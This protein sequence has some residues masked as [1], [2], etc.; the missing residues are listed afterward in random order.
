MNKAKK[1]QTDAVTDLRFVIAGGGTGGH[2]F[3][4]IALAQ[5]LLKKNSCTNILF[6]NSGNNFETSTLSA[7]GFKLKP[8]TSKGIKGRSLIKQMISAVKN[9][10]GVLQ[11]FRILKRF[12]PDIVIGVGGYSSGPVLFAA[13]LFGIKTVL[14]EQNTLP[15]IT[16]RILARFVC[17]IYVS[18]KDTKFKCNP[19]KIIFTGNPIKK[20]TIKNANSAT[21]KTEEKKYN[22]KKHND[23]KFNVFITGGSQGA[24][25]LNRIIT[26]SIQHIKNRSEYHFI[27]QTGQKDES[28]VKKVYKDSGVSSMV[29][30]FFYDMQNQYK[31]A[32]IIICRAGASTIAEITVAG[33]AAIFIPFPF[34]ADN[35]QVLNA[36]SV[37]KE[38]GGEMI[39]QKDITGNMLAQRIQYYAANPEILSV[40]TSNAKKLGKPD[41]AKTII[42]DCYALF[43]GLGDL[44]RNHSC[45]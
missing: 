22:E 28:W 33:K 19:A 38:N 34:A 7:C 26:E 39:L 2:L 32:D 44:L 11:S 45:I 15:G 43:S 13:K 30:P 36:M 3:P 24:H 29:R 37:V 8:I 9:F 23:S 14:C 18:F 31:K 4:G 42:D 1:I 27:H 21:E 17:R 35:H 6:I 5:E 41:A 40:M 16:N 10:K 12:K 25:V 20:D